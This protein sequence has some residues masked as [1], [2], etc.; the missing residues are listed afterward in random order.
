MLNHNS[1]RW[2]EVLLVEDSP[3]DVAIVRAFLDRIDVPCRFHV[4][5]DGF[6]ALCFL[7]QDSNCSDLPQPDILLLDLNLPKKDG[8]EVM[9]Q[10]RQHPNL[11]GTF[12]VVL[13]GEEELERLV[14]E[15]GLE[16]NMYLRKRADMAPLHDKLREILGHKVI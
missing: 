13:S 1:G 16:A 6:E 10:I 9:E 3:L 4:V 2:L 8:F 7:T 15:R 12:V 11:H 5:C 14:V